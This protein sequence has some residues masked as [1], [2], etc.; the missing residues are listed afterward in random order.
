MIDKQL[1]EVISI[2]YNDLGKWQPEIS[3]TAEKGKNCIWR[4]MKTSEKS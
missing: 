4:L 2:K 3:E 1:T